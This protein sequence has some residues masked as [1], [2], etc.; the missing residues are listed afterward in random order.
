MSNHRVLAIPCTALMIFSVAGCSIGEPASTPTPIPLPTQTENPNN[1]EYD[2]AQLGLRASLPGQG[3]KQI[4][5]EKL[6]DLRTNEQW[7]RSDGLLFTLYFD[8]ER[9]LTADSTQS[10]RT[11]E[12]GYL[13]GFADQNPLNIEPG[14]SQ[15][16]VRFK[17]FDGY[18]IEGIIKG[19][20]LVGTETA[21]SE[22]KAFEDPNIK[23]HTVDY[24]FIT[25]RGLYHVSVGSPDSMW[26]TETE[27]AV[28]DLLNSVQIKD[29]AK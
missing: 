22:V 2:N 17:G 6:G 7:A 14:V 4:V 3:W 9:S 8:P 19:K 26:N 13:E 5:Y 10:D 12:M 1:T 21:R 27:K 23:F 16:Q 28:N 18:R 25:G 15:E 24:V 20:S 11:Y 29:G